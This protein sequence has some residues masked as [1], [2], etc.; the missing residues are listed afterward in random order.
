MNSP[1]CLP[2]VVPWRDIGNGGVRA[3]RDQGDFTGAI[4]TTAQVVQG[5]NGFWTMWVIQ[6]AKGRIKKVGIGRTG[7]NTVS[8]YH[9]E[10]VRSR[11]EAIAACE[12]KWSELSAQADAMLEL[13]KAAE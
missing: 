5:G 3:E 13:R 11:Q 10:Q 2:S 7:G 9:P 6:T 12:L 1:G 8:L 4:V